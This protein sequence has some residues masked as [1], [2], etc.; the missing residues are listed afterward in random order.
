MIGNHE[1][2]PGPGREGT[3]TLV[4]LA[5][6]LI[7][8]NLGDGLMGLV[9]T[10]LAG[11]LGALSQG[12]VG[13]GTV[14]F[15]TITVVGIGTVMGMD[16]LASQAIGAGRT[17]AARRAMWHGIYVAGMV[18]VPLGILVWLT[19]LTLV[20]LGV[21]AELAGETGLVM[22]RL[23]PGQ[24]PWLVAIVLQAYLQAAHRAG[25]IFGSMAASNALNLAGSFLLMF[26]DEGLASL[27]LPRMGVPAW[28]ISGLAWTS[29]ACRG[30]RV[31]VLVFAVRGLEAGEDGVSVRRF[32]RALLGKIFALGIPLGLQILAEMGVFTLAGVIAGTMG[33]V[34]GAAH[35]I[36]LSLASFTF[37][38]PLGIGSATAVQVGRAIGRGDAGEARRAGNTGVGLG[39]GVMFLSALCMWLFPESLARMMTNDPAVTDL[40]ARLVLIA[41][42][43]QVFDGVQC[44]AAGALRGAGRT[45]WTMVTNFVS[46]WVVGAP[47]AVGLGIGLGLGAQGLWW[48]L[49]VGLVVAAASMSLRFL[50]LPR[51]AFAALA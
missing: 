30:V 2:L 42:A 39:G 18:S 8:F 44:V 5:L 50:S 14:L 20:S 35:Q 6:P 16:P 51:R 11:R 3:A 28:G 27:G 15:A 19:P 40:A 37:M 26:G 4:R 41:G 48:G 1:R 24:F 7:A 12:A 43:F 23:L 49:T 17:A 47:L 34:P 33:A 9:G 13:L 32:D 22:R 36:A 21:D 10:A 38:V 31:L 25:A 46:Y 29:S 45:R